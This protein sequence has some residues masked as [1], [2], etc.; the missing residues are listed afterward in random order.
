MNKILENERM[1]EQVNIKTA[2]ATSLLAPH[3]FP[4]DFAL[5]L[6]CECANKACIER[7]SITHKDYKHA[8][9]NDLVFVVVPEHYLPEFERVTKKTINYWLIMK[10][11]EKLEKRFEA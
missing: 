7:V 6:Y 5:E 8:K 9:A 3:D 11:P 2:A 10:R 4:S 1:F